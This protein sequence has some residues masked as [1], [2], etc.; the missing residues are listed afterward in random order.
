MVLACTRISWS[1][2]E[3]S[4]V[5][6]RRTNR[7]KL[8]ALMNSIK[9]QIKST[10]QGRRRR[11]VVSSGISFCLF[12]R[13]FGRSFTLVMSCGAK[14]LS[15]MTNCQAL[16]EASDVGQWH[17]TGC[18]T[19]VWDPPAAPTLVCMHDVFYVWGS[20]Q[21]DFGKS[22]PFFPARHFLNFQL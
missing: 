19:G 2:A 14:P 1:P 18:F 9:A 6:V 15:A 12:V 7:L 20:V 17:G 8:K 13:S 3:Q 5:F 21:L 4:F 10:N 22:K 16:A 11:Y